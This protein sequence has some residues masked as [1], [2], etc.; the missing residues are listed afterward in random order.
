[1]RITDRT[2]RIADYAAPLLA[3][4]V[5]LVVYLL[6]LTATVL[7][8]DSADFARQSYRLGLAHPP[9]YPLMGMLGKAVTA[10]LPLGELGWRPNLLAALSA[11]ASL[12]LGYAL[13]RRWGV[14]RLPAVLAMWT[15][16]FSPL[17]W[18]QSI[19]INPYMPQVAFVLAVMVLLEIWADRRRAAGETRPRGSVAWL[20]AAA[21]A[22]VG[23]GL[24]GHPSFALYLPAIVLFALLN[25]WRG[26]A[27]RIVLAG[28]VGAGAVVLG[29]L[30]WLGYTFYYLAQQT[31]PEA[32]GGLLSRLAT[33]LAASGSPSD[34]MLFFRGVVSG[35]YLS[36][37]V[38]HGAATVGQVS[39]VGVLLGALGA[40]VL[41][42]RRW[43][44]LLL[45][46][47]A[48][49]AQM[50]FACTLGHWH[51]HDVYRLPTYALLALLIGV[52]MSWLC[53]R[54]SGGTA[55]AALCGAAA[56]LCVGPPHGLLLAGGHQRQAASNDLLQR[57]RLEP[58]FT[59]RFA[60][61][62]RAECIG[63]LARAEP[64]AALVA[65]WGATATL[66]FLQEIEGVAPG[67]WIIGD[68]PE[69]KALQWYLR[70]PKPSRPRLFVLLRETEKQLLRRLLDSCETVEA[71]R[72]EVYVLHEVL[73]LRPSTRS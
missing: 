38:R 33:L 40:L 21:A 15:L 54:L 42:R 51:F 59:S 70:Q 58:V 67:V 16:A 45:I 35:G 24:G 52:G 62:N 3:A 71:T 36:Q 29:C 47:V 12:L 48:Y 22:L 4:A 5:P 7:D 20:L 30:P 41:A 64:D 44:S 57:M 56:V 32:Q 63:A 46:G 2:S 9:G 37:L 18:S 27:R 66:R 28:V 34:P 53:K 23:F 69:G 31:G 8:G 43:R 17:F 25:V 49:L 73:R 1:M 60:V 13:L 6:T 19:T 26:G 39:P 50:N 10:C 72:G 61:Q 65:T 11:A 14:P 55:R 68:G